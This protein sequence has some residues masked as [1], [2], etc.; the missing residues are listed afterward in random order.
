MVKVDYRTGRPVLSVR[1]GD[2]RKIAHFCRRASLPAHHIGE[3]AWSACDARL[4][5]EGAT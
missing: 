5:D 1:V 3:N 4:G 2:D